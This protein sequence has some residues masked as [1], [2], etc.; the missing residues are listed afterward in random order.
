MTTMFDEKSRYAKTDQYHAVDQRGRTVT[1]VAVPA[2]LPAPV[3]GVHRLKQGQR[4]DHLAAKYLSDPAGFWRI[5]EANDAML[6]DAL[7]EQIEI[8]IPQKTR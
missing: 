5:G 7:A 6:P 8:T 3:L 1:V 2:V 4:I